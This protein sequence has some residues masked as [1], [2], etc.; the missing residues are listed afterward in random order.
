MLPAETVPAGAAARR[1]SGRGTRAPV[2]GAAAAG[3]RD[4]VTINKHTKDATDTHILDI[5]FVFYRLIDR[6]HARDQNCIYL[7][8]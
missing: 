6:T 2:E 4:L 7:V 1:S 8:L 5:L 3:Q